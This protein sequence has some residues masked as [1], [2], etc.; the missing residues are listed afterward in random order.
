MRARRPPRELPP[1]KA[2]DLMAFS[3]GLRPGTL[4]VAVL[5][6][7]APGVPQAKKAAALVA[8]AMQTAIRRQARGSNKLGSQ[9]SSQSTLRGS[10]AG[11]LRVPSG[12]A[13]HKHPDAG[14]T[15]SSGMLQS[16][17][18]ASM[19]STGG[20]MMS[21]RSGGNEPMQRSLIRGVRTA[22]HPR[23][24]GKD[25]HESA[26]MSR[27]RGSAAG[28]ASRDSMQVPMQGGTRASESSELQACLDGFRQLA[29]PE[30]RKHGAGG[31]RPGD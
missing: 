29:K 18:R 19:G 13:R 25:E 24:E 20:F 6:S 9:R 21:K 22:L 2:S 27:T 23:A 28:A 4:L 12:A 15:R 11:G 3:E 30:G 14:A 31:G 10:I 26:F 5:V 7:V 8:E 1:V 16:I 17:G